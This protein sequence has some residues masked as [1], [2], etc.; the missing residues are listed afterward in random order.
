MLR[1]A[2]SDDMHV[3]K[4]GCWQIWTLQFASYMTQILQSVTQ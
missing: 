3:Y 1:I 2:S 4:A